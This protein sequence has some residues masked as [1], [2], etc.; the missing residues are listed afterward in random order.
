MLNVTIKYYIL[1][2]LIIYCMYYI[3][4][5]GPA[6]RNLEIVNNDVIVSKCIN[7]G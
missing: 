7:I 4:I 5:I 1:Y 3:I 2:V 6:L